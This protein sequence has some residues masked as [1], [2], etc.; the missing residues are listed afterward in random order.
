[1]DPQAAQ[2]LMQYGAIGAMLLLAVGALMWVFKRMDTRLEQ[3]QTSADVDR[4]EYMKNMQVVAEKSIEAHER[5]TIA[6]QENTK[7]IQRLCDKIDGIP[8]NP[9]RPEPPVFRTPERR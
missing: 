4:K 5:G 9:H 7:I 3:T 2:G 1:M 6:Q 8:C